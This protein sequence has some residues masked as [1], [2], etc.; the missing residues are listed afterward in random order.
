MNDN[1]AT[2]G[3]FPDRCVTFVYQRGCSLTGAGEIL[4]GLADAF[5]NRKLQLHKV[6][7]Q[8]GDCSSFTNITR[9]AVP[10][11]YK[12]LVCNREMVGIY[13]FQIEVIAV[14][15][16]QLSLLPVLCSEGSKHA[17]AKCFQLIHKPA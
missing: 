9:V 12:W 7:G 14:V 4:R 10:R 2:V 5:S 15:L 6:L 1:T 13:I 8:R 17:V 11:G 16:E 3:S